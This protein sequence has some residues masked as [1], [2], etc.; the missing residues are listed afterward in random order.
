MLDRVFE[1]AR[2]IE[3]A[4][5]EVPDEGVAKDAVSS[6]KI[7]RLLRSLPPPGEEAGDA[8]N[9]VAGAFWPR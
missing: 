2:R 1:A 8:P 3:L 4:S 7:G 5:L 6:H 9:G